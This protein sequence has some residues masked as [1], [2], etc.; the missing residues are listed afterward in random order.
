M[1]AQEIINN[2]I[3]GAQRRFT[4]SDVEDVV[5][6]MIPSSILQMDKGGPAGGAEGHMVLT[7]IDGHAAWMP[8]EANNRPAAPATE[9]DMV[10]DGTGIVISAGE[11]VHGTAIA[12]AG[13]TVAGASAALDDERWFGLKVDF[14]V[15][16]TAEGFMSDDASKKLDEGSIAYFN[17]QKWKRTATSWIF[18]CMGN[19]ITEHHGILLP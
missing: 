8:P 19:P 14:G 12:Y 13:D 18:V 10:A 7:S 16:R 11:F 3:A 15:A 9:L 5:K 6:T 1:N 17:L 4:R 2:A